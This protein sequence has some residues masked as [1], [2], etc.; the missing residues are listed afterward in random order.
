MRVSDSNPEMLRYLSEHAIA[1][2]AVFEIVDQQPFGGPLFAEFDGV[3]H[4]LGGA[5]AQAMRVEVLA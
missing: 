2:G 1:L 4:A 3:R 5:L